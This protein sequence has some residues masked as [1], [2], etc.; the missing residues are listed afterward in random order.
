MLATSANSIGECR[1]EH[2]RLPA[3]LNRV[4]RMPEFVQHRLYVPLH[5]RRIHENERLPLHLQRRLKSARPLALAALQIQRVRVAQPPEAL[6][7]VRGHLAQDVL[8]ALN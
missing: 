5:P 8:R 1:Q 2:Q 7:Q 4:Q 6:S 3:R